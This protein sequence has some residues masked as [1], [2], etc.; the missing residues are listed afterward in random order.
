MASDR[1][2]V[3]ARLAQA[4]AEA[5]VTVDVAQLTPEASLDED[6]GVDSFQLMQLAR[7]IEAAYEFRFSLA[8]WVLAQEDGDLRVGSLVDYVLA[9]ES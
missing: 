3:I 1:E 5:G 6:L 7:H 8:D 2:A 4:L 9:Q